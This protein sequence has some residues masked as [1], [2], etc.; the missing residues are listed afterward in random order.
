MCVTTDA[1]NEIGEDRYPKS[2]EFVSQILAKRFISQE[3]DK[4]VA[5]H[6]YAGCN[7]QVND[8]YANRNWHPNKLCRMMASRYLQPS[9]I[10][11]DCLENT[12]RRSHHSVDTSRLVELR[13]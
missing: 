9:W 8:W 1:G 6:W 2:V 3:C 13:L 12:D 10:D 7:H 11:M 4:F 5:G